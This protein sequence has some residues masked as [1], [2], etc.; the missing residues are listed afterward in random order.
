M[1]QAPRS[2]ALL[3][4]SF[5]LACGETTSPPLVARPELQ[6]SKT[7]PPPAPEAKL[8][9]K[10]E[11]KDA[12]K[13]EP[14]A[15]PG[16]PAATPTP[17]SP[18]APQV[19]GPAFFA[20]DKKG[21]VRLDQ[22]KFTPLANGPD[23]LIKNL[24][25]ADDG[26]LWVVGFETIYKLPTLAA[27]EFKEVARGDFKETGTID[28][29]FVTADDDLWVAGFGGVSHWDGKAWTREEKATIGAG[30]D[31]VKAIAV[32]RAGKVWV[33][34][35]NG[36]HVKDRGTWSTLDLGKIKDRLFMEGIERAA[37]GTVY[38]LAS[39]T[40]IKLG[41]GPADAVAVKLGGGSIPSY[42]DLALGTDGTI[43]ARNL[44]DLV[45]STPTT[46]KVWRKKDY[47]S[48][49]VRALAVDAAGRVWV[50][51]EI[52]V[53]I[54]GPGDAKIEWRSG[55]VPELSGEVV[56]VAVAGAGP[57]ELPTA[58]PIQTGGLKGKL[59]RGGQPVV[60]IEVELCPSPSMMFTKSPCADSS[61]KFAGRTDSNGEW[62]FAEVPL[63]AYGIAINSEG[64]WRITMGSDLGVEMKPG[65]VF[66]VGSVSLDKK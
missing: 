55:A 10:D 4:G 32:D 17:T 5:A 21:I 58:G 27:D 20:I 50:G 8:E 30:D 24:H 62:T 22:G 49:G 40:L 38:A 9:A 6:V 54:L 23:R 37:D 53:T 15:E 42:S 33:A 39:A 26:A 35:S 34:S 63:G 45:I 41:P 46:T 52:G 18:P 31:M 3:F 11:T 48:E 66:D 57:A 44:F 28:E 36:I 12:T 14:P 65:E 13:A 25:V 47:M 43:A 56:G 64:K 1:K 16:E 2:L 19:P 59:L 51:S 60:G 7:T 61:V 29:L